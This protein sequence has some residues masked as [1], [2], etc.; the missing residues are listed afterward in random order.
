MSFAY[1]FS[2]DVVFGSEI[3]Y[4]YLELDGPND[5]SPSAGVLSTIV[6]CWMPDVCDNML[7]I[8]YNNL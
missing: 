8:Q 6:I 5:W 3:S 1:V 7:L 4:L 2:L